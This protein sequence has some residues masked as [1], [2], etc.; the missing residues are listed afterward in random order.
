MVRVFRAADL[1]D[2]RL[3]HHGA[4][5][6][7]AKRKRAEKVSVQKLAEQIASD[8]FRDGSSNECDRLVLSMREHADKDISRSGWSRGPV[9]DLIA[10]H[11]K[12]AGAK[13]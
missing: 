12:A 8:L 2:T 6:M 5:P 7:K 10:K 3:T 13:R 9:A 11:L 4:K 1:L